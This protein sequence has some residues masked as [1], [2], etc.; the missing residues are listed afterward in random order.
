MGR[1]VQSVEQEK[2]DHQ[3][4]GSLTEKS[5]KFIT[6][7]ML[8]LA[9][10][11]LV[12]AVLIGIAIAVTP[13]GEVAGTDTGKD[14]GQNITYLPAPTRPLDETGGSSLLAGAQLRDPFG[15]GMILRGIITG[16]GGDLA[17]IE[18]GSNAY[19]VGKG[20][21]VAGDWTVKEIKSGQVI[22]KSDS[23]EITLEFNGR[24]QHD[25][26]EPPKEERAPEK[27]AEGAGAAAEEGGEE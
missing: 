8:Y 26:V 25:V 14:A 15:G 19:V 11:V 22:L 4:D 7:N 23:K 18:A 6:K 3:E 16:G 2:L 13:G 12:L 24:A 20:A 10:G 17:V 27:P 21:M 9:G 5:K 1:M